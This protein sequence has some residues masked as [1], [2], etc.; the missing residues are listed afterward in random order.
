MLF[1]GLTQ[2]RRFLLLPVVFA[3]GFLL[4]QPSAEGYQSLTLSW[5]PS[6]DPYVIGYHIYYGENSGG[7]DHMV[8]VSNAD[9]VTITGLVE[10]W[11]Y[12]FVATSVNAVG[13]E[14]L[15]SNQV[16][17]S[18]PGTRLNITRISTNGAPESFRITSTSVVQ[19]SWTLEASA[20]LRTW[21]SMMTG[22]NTAVN[23]TVSSSTTPA[24]FFRL[25]RP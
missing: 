23:V 20:D 11:T 12:Y 22:S 25:A 21:R 24:V 2:A 19:S 18:V 7:Y 16:S 15:P 13:L 17:Y 14:S 1:C 6:S 9:S 3:V 10:G 4:Q 8:S 5:T